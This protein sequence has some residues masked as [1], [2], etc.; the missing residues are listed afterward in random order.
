MSTVPVASPPDTSAPS[1]QI[2]EVGPRDGLQNERAVV[3]TEVKLELIEALAGTGLKRIEAGSFVSARH[4]PQMADSA[5][6][7][8]RLRR[9]SG[10]TYSALVATERG[11]DSALSVH[12]PEIAIF[13]AA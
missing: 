5:E 3:P 2:V 8:R 12:V 4:V 11:L 6:I 10:V 7:F 9:L 13:A 1:V